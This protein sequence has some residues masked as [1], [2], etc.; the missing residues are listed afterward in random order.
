MAEAVKVM[1][2]AVIQNGILV[3]QLIYRNFI[4]TDSAE[5]LDTIRAAQASL[6]DRM[7]GAMAAAADADLD[8]MASPVRGGGG[9]ASSSSSGLDDFPSLSPLNS[10][11][12]PGPSGLA[13]P[14]GGAGAAGRPSVGYRSSSSSSA[15]AK[16]TLHPEDMT[17]DK[18]R[19]GLIPLWS[20]ECKH[21]A[22]LGVTALC[23]HKSKPDCLAVG[24]G[25]TEFGNSAAGLILIWSLKN[26]TY[27]ER[28]I[29][30]VAS[31]TSLD[32]STEHPHLLA[33][34]FYN[35]SVAIY[36]VRKRTAD[37][38]QTGAG[39]I[40]G[41]GDGAAA[42]NPSSST[43]TSAP[44]ASAGA[45]VAAAGGAG[46]G[47]S[48][49]GA[50]RDG[51]DKP[52]VESAHATGKHSEPVWGVRWVTRDTQKRGEILTSISSDG[53]VLQWS[54]KKGL[55]P[56]PLM[57]LRRVPNKALLEG[58]QVTG[59]SREASALCMDFPMH[60]GTQYYA[61]TEDGLIHKC[62]VSYNE[63]TLATYASHTGPC[64][65]IR[66]SP[67]HP[68]V[69]LSCSADWTIKLWFQRQTE[70][71]LLTRQSGSDYVMDVSW[72]PSS[73]SCF[74]SVTRDGRVEIWDLAQ[75][76]LDPVVQLR[77]QKAC[78][79]ILFGVNAPIVAVG[80]ATGGV[81]VYRLHKVAMPE[82]PPIPPTE[83]TQRLLE[84]LLSL[85]EFKDKKVSEKEKAEKKK[86]DRDA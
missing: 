38:P 58:G 48:A 61:G 57:K 84:L 54:T 14:G 31:V 74:G 69:F 64:Y 24:Y 67:F 46:E 77:T 13:S 47:G 16:R 37:T 71:P 5:Q 2:R 55:V 6:A 52:A 34:G 76:P 51:D 50:T 83:Q 45:A 9:A 12:G 18:S 63:Q 21:T 53:Q 60:D 23:W 17:V 42:G 68:D 25:L 29:R 41:E 30:T 43:S 26:P 59:L 32:F 4:D 72:S 82:N 66:C 10:I 19:P 1:E 44:P 70:E 36:D 20:Y 79:T 28:I 7:L 22:G 39:A 73:A 86:P 62:S 49:A 3:Q 35:G 11:R 15:E 8:P 40:T 56:H 75:S 65:K 33:V 78:T 81:E 27:P 80:D 85:N